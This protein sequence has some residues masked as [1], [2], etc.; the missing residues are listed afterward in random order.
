MSCAISV[1]FALHPLKCLPATVPTVAHVGEHNVLVPWLR[2]GIALTVLFRA[3]V[4]VLR[5]RPGW[6]GVARC[7]GLAKRVG[8]G[9][10]LGRPLRR[11]W[12]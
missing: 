2:K 12:T 1:I 4:N 8:V 5:A 6:H 10:G 11:A 9:K 7:A 3:G